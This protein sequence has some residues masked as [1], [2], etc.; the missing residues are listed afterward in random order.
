MVVYKTKINEF[1]KLILCTGPNKGSGS[2][3][4]HEICDDMYN[5]SVK[6]K[7][8]FISKVHSPL[9]LTDIFV[10]LAAHSMVHPDYVKFQKMNN[11]T[12]Q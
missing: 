9:F 4:L 12:C 3:K 7:G 11:I 8:D 5:Q 6:E 2:K 1:K 10:C